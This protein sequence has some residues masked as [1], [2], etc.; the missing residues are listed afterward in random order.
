MR[1]ELRQMTYAT[2]VPGDLPFSAFGHLTRGRI[3]MGTLRNL[4]TPEDYQDALSEA[5][6]ARGSI[7]WGTH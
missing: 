6:L 3:T 2:F 1:R 5:G 7:D 4:N